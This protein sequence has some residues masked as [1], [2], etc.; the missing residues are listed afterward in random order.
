MPSTRRIPTPT[1]LLIAAWSLLIPVIAGCK[2]PTPSGDLYF[3]AE[4]GRHSRTY[5]DRVESDQREEAEH[6]RRY[7][8]DRID[9]E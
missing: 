2:S 4:H 9:D 5:D 8:G 6:R 1:R 3:N 7:H